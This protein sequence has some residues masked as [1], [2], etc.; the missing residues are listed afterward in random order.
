MTSE[1]MRAA[2]A[3]NYSGVSIR[4][5]RG[6]LAQGLRHSRVSRG[7][8]LVKRE[9]LDEYLAKFEHQTNRVNEIVDNVMAGMTGRKRGRTS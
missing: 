6:W 8:V 2:A 9:W 3:A 5:L 1:W 7:T 4:T